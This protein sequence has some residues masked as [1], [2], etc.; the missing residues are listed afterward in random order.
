M[1]VP[2]RRRPHGRGIRA[3][4]TPA[5]SVDRAG[6]DRECRRATRGRCTARST[7]LPGRLALGWAGQQYANIDRQ[8]TLDGAG[9]SGCVYETILSNNDSVGSRCD[10]ECRYT[11]ETAPVPRPPPQPSAPR[12]TRLPDRFARSG[13]RRHTEATPRALAHHPSHGRP[14][15]RAS[16]A[17]ER[18]A[19]PRRPT[20]P[21]ISVT[22][23]VRRIDRPAT[24]RG[25]RGTPPTKHLPRV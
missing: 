1:S 2:I 11:R 21:T 17:D 20:G 9:C 8:R 10:R 15:R 6:T 25:R 13:H 14:R 3:S 5:A 7:R 16:C 22:P 4:G 23:A 18:C 19:R 24:R 12:A